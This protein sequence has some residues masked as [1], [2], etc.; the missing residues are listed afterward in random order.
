MKKEFWCV[1]SKKNNGGELT[2]AYPVATLIKAAEKPANYEVEITGTNLEKATSFIEFFDSEELARKRIRQVLDDSR[3]T[4]KEIL[5][6][7]KF[8][9]IPGVPAIAYYQLN[10]GT[11]CVQVSMKEV[12]GFQIY[13][14]SPQQA[15]DDIP[16]LMKR[17]AGYYLA[18]KQD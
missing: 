1:K 15:L 8:I 9:E 5:M 3:L 14:Q 6:N 17:V 10:S 11:V 12:P 16:K 2:M 4:A 13:Y 18:E 7:Y